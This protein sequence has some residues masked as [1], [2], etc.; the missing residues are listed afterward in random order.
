MAESRTLERFCEGVHRSAGA[1]AGWGPATGLG[2]SRSRVYQS[3]ALLKC[4]EKSGRSRCRSGCRARGQQCNQCGRRP[5][6]R[7]CRFVQG[8]RRAARRRGAGEGTPGGRAV[9]CAADRSPGWSVGG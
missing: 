7:A 9:G 5:G 2:S 4:S 6:R 8:G 3:L 1:R